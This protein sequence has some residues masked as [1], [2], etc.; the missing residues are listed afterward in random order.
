MSEEE[1]ATN[2][3]PNG[4]PQDQDKEDLARVENATEYSE[5]KS[6]AVLDGKTLPEWSVA[7]SGAE[8]VENPHTGGDL[9]D[10]GAPITSVETA[11]ETDDAATGT[12]VPPAGI[13]SAEGSQ[14]ASE[15]APPDLDQLADFSRAETMPFELDTDGVQ[16]SLEPTPIEDLPLNLAIDTQ[17]VQVRPEVANPPQKRGEP[18]LGYQT[19]E[20][21]L[22]EKHLPDMDPDQ[23]TTLPYTSH[24]TR[25]SCY[26]SLETAVKTSNSQPFAVP[27]P[28]VPPPPS[29][30]PPPTNK[31]P[32]QP[33]RRSL[34]CL[35]RMMVAATFLLVITVLCGASVIFYQYMQICQHLTGCQ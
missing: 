5:N 7:E 33:W 14:P 34:G 30:P 4:E 32:D 13:A 8:Q 12:P 31:S 17:P 1:A 3:I 2:G 16:P 9:A 35:L 19:G 25:G 11:P 15:Q 24:A 28:P 23:G 21:S 29:Y 6:P 10:L 26:R 27:P 20:S 18:S 22:T